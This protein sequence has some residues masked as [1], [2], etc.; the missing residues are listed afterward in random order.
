MASVDH[1]LKISGIQGDSQDR[2]H[3]DQIEVQSWSWGLVRS[4]ATAGGAAGKPVF[5]DLSITKNVDRSTPKLVGACATGKHFL[6]VVLAA[7]RAEGESFDFLVIKLSD[8]TI[9]RFE[10]SGEDAWV[11][12]DRCFLVSVRQNR[13]P[14]HAAEGRRNTRHR[15]QV[16]LGRQ[17]RRVR[18][19][20]ISSR[21]V[22]R[23]TS[24]SRSARSTVTQVE[25][26]DSSLAPRSPSTG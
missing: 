20:C 17:A 22:T 4:T 5:E 24:G 16:E 21:G 1:S 10:T 7:R 25:S 23:L 11:L 26:D 2:A 19:G 15:D 3:K 9:P 6:E 13:I 12:P 18:S 14:L 8:V